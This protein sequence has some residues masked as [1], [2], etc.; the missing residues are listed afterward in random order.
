MRASLGLACAQAATLCAQVIGQHRSRPR[1]ACPRAYTII[2]FSVFVWASPGCSFL[3]SFLFLCSFCLCVSALKLRSL[4]I[5]PPRLCR[6]AVVSIQT[7]PPLII[8]NIIII[9][10]NRGMRS[11]SGISIQ[12]I[13]RPPAANRHSL[14][15]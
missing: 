13:A 15:V 9:N 6:I 10:N 11:L 2:P 12:T 7:N 4:C 3:F 8:M 14:S 5:H 1:A